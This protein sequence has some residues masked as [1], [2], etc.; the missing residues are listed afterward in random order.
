[1]V[2]QL[3]FFE[4]QKSN[5][6]IKSEIVSKYFWMWAQVMKTR[7]KSGKMAYIDL[8]SGQGVYE[9]GSKSTPILI[10]EKALNES[11]IKTQLISF[12]NDEDP[13]C[14]EKLQNAVKQIKNIDELKHKP[15]FSNFT[16][17]S[18]IEKEFSEYR[19]VPTLLFVDP[20]GYKGLTLGLIKSVLKDWGCDCFFFFN[21]LRVN[22]AINNDK[23]LCHTDR[24][25][26]VLLDPN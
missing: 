15:V 12:F 20:F 19:F 5:S 25:V 16:V 9:D 1:M 14:I 4:K 3:S 17:D 24:N 7:T 26:I 10:L 13:E 23:F 6:Q 11:L 8:Y 21:Y 18:E 22:A 2:Q